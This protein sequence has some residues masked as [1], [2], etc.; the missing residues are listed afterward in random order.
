M[1]TSKAY[2]VSARIHGGDLPDEWVLLA[3]IAT[4]GCTA[5]WIQ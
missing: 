3:I 1:D 5:A 4:R 2:T